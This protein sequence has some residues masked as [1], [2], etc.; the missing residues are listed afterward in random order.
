MSVSGFYIH[1]YMHMHTHRE[2][3]G[4]GRKNVK[5]F[6]SSENVHHTFFAEINMGPR[7][8]RG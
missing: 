2:R 7:K 4:G 6:V 1:E 3:V 5:L 8:K